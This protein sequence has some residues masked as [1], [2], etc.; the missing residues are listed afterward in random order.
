[1]KRAYGRIPEATEFQHISG[2]RVVPEVIHG[3]HWSVTFGR[4]TAL[5]TFAD[6]WHGFTFP[7]PQR[8]AKR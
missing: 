2:C 1:M 3:W 8:Q 4:W 5:V 7:Q 6:G